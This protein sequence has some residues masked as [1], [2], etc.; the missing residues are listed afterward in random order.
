MGRPTVDPLAMAR[1][2]LAWTT[3]LQRY[4]TDAWSW[5]AESVWTKD[6]AA[7]AMPL[8]PFPVAECLDCPDGGRYLGQAE[9][10]TDLDW[11][12]PPAPLGVGGTCRVD[13]G[14]T[15]VPMPYLPYIIRRWQRL[16]KPEAVLAV[17][18]PRRMRMS[19]AMVGAHTWLALFH[20]YVNAYIVSSKQ[21]K[22]GE[23]VGRAAHILT[24]LTQQAGWPPELVRWTAGNLVPGTRTPLVITFPDTES[25]LIGVAEGPD[26]LRQYTATAILA[27]E[28]GTWQWPRATY[29]AMLPCCEGGGRVAL[30]SSA[31]PGFWRSFVSGE[32]TQ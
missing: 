22:S 27:D 28:V 19:W 32:L 8:K 13:A 25:R 9:A 14:H 10:M 4:R 12:G 17:P 1:V 29:A 11:R 23:L 3:R 16:R 7:P 15:L 31:Y 21:E 30:V 2:S 18:K 6:E 5:I 26:Q 20:G 24:M